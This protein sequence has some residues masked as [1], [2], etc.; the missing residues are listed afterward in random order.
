MR[1]SDLGLLFTG[2]RITEE[3]R[4]FIFPVSQIPQYLRILEKFELY[5]RRRMTNC[6]YLVGCPTLRRGMSLSW[7][8]PRERSSSS[9]STAASSPCAPSI[10][11]MG[12]RVM[13]CLLA[14]SG[15]WNR[16]AATAAS[17]DEAFFLLQTFEEATPEGGEGLQLQVPLCPNGAYLLAQI[18]DNIDVV[19]EEWYP[20]LTDRTVTGECI[21]QK[22]APCVA[23]CSRLNVNDASGARNAPSGFIAASLPRIFARQSLSNSSSSLIKPAVPSSAVVFHTF[24]F[25]DIVNEAGIAEAIRCPRFAETG[26]PSSCVEQSGAGCYAVELETNPRQRPRKHRLMHEVT[27]GAGVLAPAI[28]SSIVDLKTKT[29]C[30]CQACLLSGTVVNVKLSDYGISRFAT[31]YGF[32]QPEGNPRLPPPPKSST[33]RSTDSPQTSTRWGLYYTASSLTAGTLLKTPASETTSIRYL[34]KGCPDWP[35]LELIINRC[36]IRRE[37]NKRPAASE[38]LAALCRPEFLCLRAWIQVSARHGVD[39][40]IARSPGFEPTKAR[41]W[42]RRRGSVGAATASTLFALVAESTPSRWCTLS[43]IPIL[44]SSLTIRGRR[45]PIYGP[46]RRHGHC[47]TVWGQVHLYDFAHNKICLAINNLMPDAV[48]KEATPVAFLSPDNERAP[49][50]RLQPTK[51]NKLLVAKGS[52][53]F[54]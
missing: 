45:R 3:D 9:S 17:Y 43:S 30:L 21:L 11:K 20:G 32:S 53:L 2:K 41:Q 28:P 6:S 39:C 25:D 8:L 42:K 15:Y 33:G 10:L 31:P 29:M 40:M 12:K 26:I 13:F 24:S 38:V 27:P 47:C 34:K 52:K 22:S 23:C 19:I 35:H 50:H 14:A 1:Q 51:N 7:L 4:H 54:I 16:A 46:N 37:P 5:Y 48:F 18:A 44:V 49:I 36:L